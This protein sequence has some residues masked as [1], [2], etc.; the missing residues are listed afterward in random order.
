[1]FCQVVTEEEEVTREE[2]LE[3]REFINAVVDTKVM[4][5]ASQWMVD[6]GLLSDDIGSFKRF[7]HKMWFSIYPR[8]RRVKVR[9]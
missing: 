2:I 1:M 5:I 3:E 9:E 8:A 4:D 6:K 7:L